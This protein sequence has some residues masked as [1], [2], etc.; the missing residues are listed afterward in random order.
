MT[1]GRHV[2]ACPMRWSDLDA[3]GHVHN[4][5]YLAYLQEARVDMLFIHAG[6]R[7]AEGLAAGVVVAR[8][9]I[10][11]RR[12]LVPRPDPVRVESWVAQIGAAS[13]TIGYEVVDPPERPGR[14]PVTYAVAASRLVPY[15]LAASRP[16]RL[17]PEERAVL[18][19][20]FDPDGPQPVR[21]A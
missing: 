4:A 12:P 14:E 13:F 11:Y 6:R 18:E 20:F 21:R 16:R 17:R 15:D 7:G 9:E 8:H 5:V 10:E 19:E 1:V 2:V 3:H